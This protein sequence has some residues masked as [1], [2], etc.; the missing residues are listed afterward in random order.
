MNNERYNGKK[1]DAQ[2]QDRNQHF[3][4]GK[5]FTFFPR[6]ATS[7]HVNRTPYFRPRRYTSLIFFHGR[8]FPVLWRQGSQET[9]Q[10]NPALVNVQN[11]N[12]I[13][14]SFYG[15]KKLQIIIRS[16][17]KIVNRLKTLLSP[18]VPLV[19]GNLSIG[20]NRGKD[21]TAKNGKRKKCVVFR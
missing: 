6:P 14:P 9:K 2:D 11:K 5:T 17:R 12:T 1:D 18:R 3:D 16:K 19:K 15:F 10:Q 7:S 21:V 20:K 4:Q 13:S 8:N